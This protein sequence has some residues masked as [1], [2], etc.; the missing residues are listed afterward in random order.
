VLAGRYVITDFIGAGG[1]GAVYGARHARTGRE[2]AIKVLLPELATRETVMQR[3]M[4]EARAAGALNHPGIVEVIDLDVDQGVHFIVMERLEGEELLTRIR[5]G[6]PL[7]PGFVARI[8]ADLADAISCAH[9]H[10]P[11]IIHRDLKPQNV[12]LARKGRQRDVV[13]VLDFGIAKL[14]E[15]D[16][17]DQ[18]L[19]RSG[20]I[21]GTP[22]YM[23]PEQLRNTK[24]VDE[25]ADIY[26]IGVIL[27]HALT[28]M[29]PFKG[30]SFPD[31]VMS[32]NTATP[33]S[34]RSL[35]ADVPPGL[36]TVIERAMARAKELRYASASLLR[37]A[38]LP[39]AV[40]RASSAPAMSFAETQAPE[41]TTT[42]KVFPAP[43]DTTGP[44]TRPGRR[45]PTLLVGGIAV[46]VALAAGAGLALR[47]PS[48][49]HSPQAPPPTILPAV[50]MPRVVTPPDAAAVA[51][52]PAEE[53][54]AA[55]PRPKS[56]RA[57]RPRESH[58][59]LPALRPR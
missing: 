8:G 7:D 23:S 3:F 16:T 33:P 32:I 56:E 35:R 4:A 54:K 45:R 41:A 39:F 14:I 26:A 36:A 2:L 46:A 1:M 17:L 47:G 40:E 25:R 13:K 55:P 34:L 30:E 50:E 19:T 22:L 21:Y 44:L 27:F 42:A 59:D 28:G 11:K 52:P 43:L 53:P 15:A 31:L 38:L 20:E 6:H 18:S 58:D 48:G 37:D 57:K 24:D 49:D 12:M 51:R 5:D 10:S 9:L 29:T